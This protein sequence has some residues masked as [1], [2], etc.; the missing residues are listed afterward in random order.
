[1]LLPPIYF[2]RIGAYSSASIGFPPFNGRWCQRTAPIL[3]LVPGSGD[4]PL[5]TPSIIR[6]SSSFSFSHSNPC[7][8]VYDLKNDP[9]V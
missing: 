7:S 5:S 8:S 3:G 6:C 4:Q 2:S 1:M 9:S